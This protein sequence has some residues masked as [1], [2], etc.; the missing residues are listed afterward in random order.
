MVGWSGEK[1]NNIDMI[2]PSPESV[3]AVTDDKGID[4]D[5]DKIDNGLP[6]CVFG[7]TRLKVNISE[8]RKI[9]LEDDSTD[10]EKSEKKHVLELL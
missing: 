3:N 9:Y 2:I 8:T 4:D 1:D 10:S 6:K 7:T 5:G